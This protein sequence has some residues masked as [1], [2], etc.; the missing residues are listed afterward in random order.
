[1]KYLRKPIIIIPI[2]I[3]LL[4]G[5]I[6]ASSKYENL[7]VILSFLSLGLMVITFIEALISK[8]WLK[9]ILYFL[10]YGV[11]LIST[12]GMIMLVVAMMP[13]SISG[14]S[15]FYNNKLNSHLNSDEPIELTIQCKQEN[16]VGIGPGGGDYNASCVFELNGDDYEKLI[17]Q[18]ENNKDFQKMKSKDFD[19]QIELNKLD[20]LK[21]KKFKTTGYQ[22]V[23]SLS[24]YAKILITTDNKYCLFDINY[25]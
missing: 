11:I 10:L 16:I 19:Y 20:C 24:M 5:A 3:V 6:A 21:N 22:S 12:F 9:S 25:F 13:R 8:K 14:T 17:S 2:I 1:M 15:E 18:I 7:A 4:V 23:N